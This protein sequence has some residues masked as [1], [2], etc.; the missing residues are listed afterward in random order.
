VL[1]TTGAEAGAIELTLVAVPNGVAV[2]WVVAAGAQERHRGEDGLDL[3]LETTGGADGGELDPSR[4]QSQGEVRGMGES[5]WEI[6]LALRRV[7]SECECSGLGVFL[8]W[9]GSSS[10]M[11]ILFREWLHSILS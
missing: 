2:T 4:R 6:S 10:K 5:R 11:N 3:V 1:G 7:G 9:N 8:E